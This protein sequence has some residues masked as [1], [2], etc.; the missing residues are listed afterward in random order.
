[1]YL[2]LNVSHPS[3]S[4]KSRGFTARILRRNRPKA[5]SEEHEYLQFI[6]M[7]QKLHSLVVEPEIQVDM[8]TST[9]SYHSLQTQ[10]NEHIK[11][12][13]HFLQTCVYITILRS[14]NTTASSSDGPPYLVPFVCNLLI[15]QR[16]SS[17]Q[18]H[19]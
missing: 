12:H 11:K 7:E 17:L 13:R 5:K 10:I 3:K 14:A 19:H 9:T 4:T 8:T 16:N 15:I 1:M 18:Y 2:T 6:L